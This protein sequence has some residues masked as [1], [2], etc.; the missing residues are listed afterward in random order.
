MYMHAYVSWSPTTLDVSHI[1]IRILKEQRAEAKPLA[2]LWRERERE[3]AQCGDCH[4]IP[5][6]R[7]LITTILRGSGREGRGAALKN[8]IEPGR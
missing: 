2:S 3:R 4:V 8:L 7:G 6:S 5:G 1:G